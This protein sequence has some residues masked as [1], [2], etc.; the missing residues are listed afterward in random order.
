M[1]DVDRS[2]VARKDTIFWIVWL[3]AWT[4][5]W[6]PPLFT[7]VNTWRGWALGTGSPVLIWT[8]GLVA[9]Q[10]ATNWIHFGVEKRSG[11]LFDTVEVIDWQKYGGR[12]ELSQVL[13]NPER[14]FARAGRV[15]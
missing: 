7:E 12:P 11:E 6:F 9:A 3:L 5:I 15:A 13:T 10:I 1:A 4:L 2:W 14:A 8:L